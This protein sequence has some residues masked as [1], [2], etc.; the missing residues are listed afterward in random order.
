ML[1][2]LLFI[3]EFC[4]RN[5]KKGLN[6]KVI[7]MV[8]DFEITIRENNPNKPQVWKVLLDKEFSAKLKII[9]KEIGRASCRERV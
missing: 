9:K 5:K 8:E 3:A 1:K 2:P 4:R 7:T 6:M